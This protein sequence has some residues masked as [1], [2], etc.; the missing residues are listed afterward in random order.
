MDVRRLNIVKPSAKKDRA[1]A[2]NLKKKADKST[3]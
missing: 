3:G 1:L 2:K